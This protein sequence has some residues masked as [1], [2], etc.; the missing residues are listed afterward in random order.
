VLSIADVLAMQDATGQ[1]GFNAYSN[2]GGV[3]AGTNRIQIMIDGDTGDRLQLAGMSATLV[4]QVAGYD[5]YNVNGAMIQFLVSSRIE[6]AQP[7]FATTTFASNAGVDNTYLRSDV[8]S[9]AVTFAGPVTVDTTG[10]TPSIALDVGGVI[11]TAHY[12]SGSGNATLVFSYTVAAGDMDPNGIS[13]PAGTIALNGG[14]ISDTFGG[15]VDLDITA[16]ADNPAHVVNGLA[17]INLST[18]SSGADNGFVI[19]GQAASDMSGWSVSSAGD[20]NG[21]GLADLIVGASRSDPA[22]GVDAGRSYV[23]FGR[24]APVSVD[25]SSLTSGSSTQGFVINGQAASDL[26]GRTISGAG[27]VNGDGLMDLIVGAA[28]A[29]I[30]ASTDAGRSY[31]IFG[32]TDTSAVDLSSLTG[33]ASSQGFAING[34]SAGDYSGM[35]VSNAGDVNGDGLA[36]LILGAYGSDVGGVTDAGRAYVVFGKTSTGVVELSSFSSGAS[37]QGFVLNGQSASDYAGWSVSDAGDVNGDGLADVIVGAYQSDPAG[38][39][40]AGRSYVVF[41]KTGLA[42]I[43]LSSLTGGTSTQ[44]FVING[45]STTDVSGYSVSSAGDVNGDGLADLIVGA[46]QA[47][48]PGRTNAGQSYV[49]F[50]KRHGGR[51]VSTDQWH[52]HARLCHQRA[53]LHRFERL[54]CIGRGRYQWRRAGRSAGGG[55]AERSGG[56]SK[57]GPCLRDLWQNRRHD[58]GTVRPDFGCQHTGLCRQRAGRQR[59]RGRFSVC[60]G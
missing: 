35:S 13:V 2:W 28:R 48:P 52:Q 15:P 3:A 43:D 53:E 9:V 51:P 45:M 46:Y 18:L 57:R 39:T 21:D 47:D 58:G 12:V 6:V 34:Q 20:V 1:S 27:D 19:N 30:G 59:L 37:T 23:I 40:D 5:A 31:V 24:T 44:G 29:D 8:V 17:T 14:V 11:R 60:R 42:P 38:G 26:S 32:K 10:G 22:G 7:V 16:L 56:D 50:G 36:D 33:G 54:R 41:G 49:V 25:L 55:D 4:G